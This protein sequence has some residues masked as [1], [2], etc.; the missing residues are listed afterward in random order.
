MGGVISRSQGIRN[1]G[2][3]VVYDYVYMKRLDGRFVA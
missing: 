1:E 3:Y 2:C